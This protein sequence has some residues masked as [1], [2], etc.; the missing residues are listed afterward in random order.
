MYR[1]SSEPCGTS[2][3]L[4]G[5]LSHSRSFSESRRSLEDSGNHCLYTTGLPGP[6]R[7]AC[8]P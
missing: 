4:S 8:V 2:R 5:V 3:A 1:S 6:H 7:D